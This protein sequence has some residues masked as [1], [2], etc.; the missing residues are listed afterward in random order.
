MGMGS[1]TELMHDACVEVQPEVSHDD[2]DHKSNKLPSCPGWNI[3]ECVCV[4]APRSKVQQ[5][6]R[7]EIALAR[8]QLTNRFTL[9]HCTG[10]RCMQLGSDIMDGR[11]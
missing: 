2:S 11:T 7:R 10:A 3:T 6:R 8:H 1:P 9:V 4:C 5:K